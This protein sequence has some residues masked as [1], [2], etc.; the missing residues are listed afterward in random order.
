[1]KLCKKDI[2]STFS[3]FLLVSL[4]FN[5]SFCSVSSRSNIA[6]IVGS[7]L[8]GETT[9]HIGPMTHSILQDCN[10]VTRALS[11]G[12]KVAFD[13]RN[14]SVLVSPLQSLLPCLALQ[15]MILSM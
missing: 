7:I 3:C 8:N 5:E 11:C 10:Q 6:D 12:N 14:Y 1:M 15:H 13:P 9:Q 4:V 2:V